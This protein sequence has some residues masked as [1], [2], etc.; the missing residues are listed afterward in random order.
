MPGGLGG[1]VVGGW[2]EDGWFGRFEYE[3]LPVMAP[4]RTVGGLFGF[5]AGF[6]Y[7]RAADDAK[8]FAVPALTMLGVRVFP[9]R[10][11]VGVGIYALTIDERAG[12][13]GAGAWGPIGMASV[14]VDLWGVRAG[15]DLRAT[16]HLNL[17]APDFT[18]LQLGISVG[19]TWSTVRRGRPYY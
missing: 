15:V 13:W 3:A 2:I 12:D 19:Y 9:V 18:Q 5:S 14:S 6:E 7:W 11:V 4:D 16:R 1:S 17:G 10:A 8:G